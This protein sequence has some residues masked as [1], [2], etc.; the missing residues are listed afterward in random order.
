MAQCLI[1]KEATTPTDALTVKLNVS[2]EKKATSSLHDKMC[3]L[4][5]FNAGSWWH[6]CRAKKHFEE[7]QGRLTAANMKVAGFGV[8]TSLL[9][10]STTGD[11]IQRVPLYLARVYVKWCFTHRG[12]QAA[13]APHK[14]HREITKVHILGGDHG[15]SGNHW[16][17]YQLAVM[18]FGEFKLWKLY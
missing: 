18:K 15:P 9:L 6:K 16:I 1:H 8:K 10:S 11:I 17:S 13:L 14:T 2:E 12:R 4:Q 7:K 3:L 5:L